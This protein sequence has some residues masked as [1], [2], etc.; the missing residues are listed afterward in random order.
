MRTISSA[1]EQLPKEYEEAAEISGAPP[2]RIFY[3]IIMPQLKTPFA[4]SFLII[5]LYCFFS[6]VIILL[7]GGIG[8]TTLEAELY[9]VIQREGHTTLSAWI[10]CIETLIASAALFLYTTVRY[11]TFG[12]NKPHRIRTRI[13]I[14]GIPETLCF[15]ILISLITFCLLIPLCTLFFYSFL[16]KGTASVT[17]TIWKQVLLS[18]SFTHAFFQTI[19]I[20]IGT[21][22][23]SIITALFFTY[24]IYDSQKNI[25]RVFPFFPLAV[26]SIVLGTGWLRL[27]ITPSIFLLIITQTALAWPF[28]WMQIEAGFSQM[29]PSVF[30]AAKLFSSSRIDAFFR[31]VLPLCK[32]GIGA[33]FCSVFAI[34]AGDASLPLLLHIPHVE[35]LALLLFRLAGTYRFSESAA[36][37]GVL[38]ILTST[39]FG[40]NETLKSHSKT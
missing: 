33:A 3:T 5:F 22:G 6:F 32:T 15:I 26:S 34:S 13:P 30:E 17:I 29:P 18:H 27:D 36:V 40:L 9:R 21:A 31:I 23:L 8:V 37:A 19:Q 1:W 7:V 14:R 35:N 4:A 39:L 24:C 25:Y 2:F 38:I 28:A 10:A 16:S 12:T 20:G 11:K